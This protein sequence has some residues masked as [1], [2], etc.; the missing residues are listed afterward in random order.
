[1]NEKLIERKLREKVKEIGGLALKL[2]SNYFTGLPDRMI[3]LPK[4]RI[5]FAEIKTTGQ[6]PTKRQLAVHR[7]LRRLG[8]QVWVVDSEE[9]LKKLLCEMKC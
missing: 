2:E 1:M 9:V 4:E 5:I 3:L 6:K 8:F 7:L